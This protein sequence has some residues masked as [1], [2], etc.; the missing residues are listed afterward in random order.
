MLRMIIIPKE[1]HEFMN[2]GIQREIEKIA[3]AA[4]VEMNKTARVHEQRNVREQ[5]KTGLKQLNEMIQKINAADKMPEALKWGLL[6]AGYANGMQCGDL[7]SES[8]LNDVIQVIDQTFMKSELRFKA[9]NRPW[10]RFRKRKG[11]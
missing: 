6:A 11:R 8:E 10:N 2:K 5:Q 3:Q 7:M 4:G 9:E 1:D